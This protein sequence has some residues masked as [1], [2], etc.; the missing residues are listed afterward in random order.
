MKIHEA[1]DPGLG[2]SDGVAALTGFARLWVRQ[3]GRKGRFRVRGACR[4]LDWGTGLR[5]RAGRPRR[6]AGLRPEG[7]GETGGGVFQAEGVACAKAL[8]CACA[9][10]P[11]HQL[12][13]RPSC[14]P[15]TSSCS[16]S[17]SHMPHRKHCPCPP[18]PATLGQRRPAPPGIACPDVLGGEVGRERQWGRELPAGRG[19]RH[20]A[21]CP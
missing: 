5:G 12:W 19:P 7:Q 18:C 1:R 11:G 20:A 6:E 14:L 17:S 2:G 4:Q 9:H 3:R 21:S 8:R 13:T 10:P 16:L 15:L